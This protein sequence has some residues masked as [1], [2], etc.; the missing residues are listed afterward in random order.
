MKVKTVISFVFILLLVPTISMAF[1][2]KLMGGLEVFKDEFKMESMTQN[3]K[4]FGGLGF[5]KGSEK[6]RFEGSVLISTDFRKLSTDVRDYYY[7]FYKFNLPLLYKFKFWELNAPYFMIGASGSLIL[8]DRTDVY[9]KPWKD[10][11][12]KTFID[13]G[14][15][16]GA[17]FE[18]D[19][20]GTS[21]M[22]EGRYYKGLKELE[23]WGYKFKRSGF[24]ILLAVRFWP[25][26]N[27][28]DTI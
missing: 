19:F 4:F 23:G 25:K 10:H 11:K 13:Y 3:Q 12:N 18:I 20:K 26:K 1:E 6:H 16:F 22:L 27:C 28:N 15:L 5:E 17:G 21:F 7:R 8:A 2:I 14:L 24:F 9:G